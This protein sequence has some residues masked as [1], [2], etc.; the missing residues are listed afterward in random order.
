MITTHRRHT[1]LVHELFALAPAFRPRILS[2]SRVEATRWGS[3]RHVVTA[4][5]GPDLVGVIWFE[6]QVWH[7]GHV[8]LERGVAVLSPTRVW[9]SASDP[10]AALFTLAG[11]VPDEFPLTAPGAS[12]ISA[13]KAGGRLRAAPR[14]ETQVAAR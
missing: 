10:I 6:N 14:C 8:V 12:R 5:L 4:T 9:S 7:T 11:V 1:R 13:S 3:P 2:L